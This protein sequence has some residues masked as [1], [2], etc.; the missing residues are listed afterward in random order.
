MFATTKKRAALYFLYQQKTPARNE[1]SK[2]IKQDTYIIDLM[3]KLLLVTI[4]T[5][6]PMK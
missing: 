5:Q 1:N 4:T 6:H 2:P 3:G